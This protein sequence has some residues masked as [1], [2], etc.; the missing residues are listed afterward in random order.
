MILNFVLANFPRQSKIFAKNKKIVDLSQ[1]LNVCRRKWIQSIL[2]A[3][4]ARI[5]MG[6]NIKTEE[7]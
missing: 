7:N 6:K 3:Q 1:E 2:W 5:F 4:I